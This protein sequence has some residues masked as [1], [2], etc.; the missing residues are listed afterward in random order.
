[1]PVV[2]D[3]VARDG[4]KV[5]EEKDNKYSDMKKSSL[6]AQSVK[7]TFC[8]PL[9]QYMETPLRYFGSIRKPVI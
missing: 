7:R 3:A 6:R 5:G 4:D 9:Y 1:M 8:Y 2:V